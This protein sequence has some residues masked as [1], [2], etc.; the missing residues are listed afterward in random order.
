MIVSASR[1]TD[2]PACYADWFFERLYDGYALVRNPMNAHQVSRV[3][4]RE[5]TVDG[6][7]FWTKNPAP[8]LDRLHELEQYPYYFQFTLNPYGTDIEPGVPDKGR[9]LLPVF[10]ELSVRAGKDRVI[11]RY[12]PVLF[13][14]KYDFAYHAKYFGR[15]AELLSGYTDTCEI[16]FLSMYAKTVRNTRRL[17]IRQ[18]S[19]AERRDLLGQIAETAR[20]CGITPRACGEPALQKDAGIDSSR[21]IDADRIGRIAGRTVRVPKDPSQRPECGCAVSV[22]IG[23][24]DTCPHRCAYCY[25]NASPERAC[26]NAQNH[27]PA[28]PILFGATGDLDVVRDRAMPMFTLMQQTLPGLGKDGE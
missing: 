23:A 15:L 14:E 20:S 8:M 2:I 1:R 9:V 19:F 24:Y 27:D 21:C 4:L 3:Q 22:D 18:G 10:R 25:A 13:T 17:G 11:W 12:N 6:F 26:R 16:S 5:D 28:A 7:V